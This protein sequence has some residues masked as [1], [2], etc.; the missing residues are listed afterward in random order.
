M[1]KKKKMRLLPWGQFFPGLPTVHSLSLHSSFKGQNCDDVRHG[2]NQLTGK[3]D[4]IRFVIIFYELSSLCYWCWCCCCC[5]CCRFRF[6]LFFL[7]AVQSG[8][9]VRN[10]KMGSKM[11]S[12]LRLM[13]QCRRW[14]QKWSSLLF[15]NH[16]LYSAFMRRGLKVSLRNSIISRLT[17]IG[18]GLKYLKNAFKT[19]N[20]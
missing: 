1:K 12:G 13:A 18:E 6:A 3:R 8:G 16:I 10:G 4:Q 9:I 15:W 7:F 17:N 5:Q 14:L 19:N 2:D 11:A 20:T